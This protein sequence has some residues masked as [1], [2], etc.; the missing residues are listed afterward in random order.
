[1]LTIVTATT[2][3]SAKDSIVFRV[4]FIPRLKLWRKRA[5]C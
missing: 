4:L 2:A 1:M 5:T 3:I